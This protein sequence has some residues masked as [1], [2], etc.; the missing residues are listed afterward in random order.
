MGRFCY[1]LKDVLMMRRGAMGREEG[2][3]GMLTSRGQ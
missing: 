1:Y 2:K 3:Q